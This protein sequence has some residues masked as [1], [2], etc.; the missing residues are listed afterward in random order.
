MATIDYT[1]IR[2]EYLPRQDCFDNDEAKIHKLKVALARLSP[3]DQA[4]IIQYCEDK[5]LQKLAARFG[6]SKAYMHKRIAQ[7][8]KEIKSRL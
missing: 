2:G 6:V 3:S 7:I 8:R 1:S 5:S 4:I